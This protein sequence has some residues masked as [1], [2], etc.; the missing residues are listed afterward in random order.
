MVVPRGDGSLMPR[1]IR[2]TLFL[3]SGFAGSFFGSEEL[4]L[5]DLGKFMYGIDAGGVTGFLEAWEMHLHIASSCGG[6]DVLGK[7]VGFCV[8]S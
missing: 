7:E 8:K 5:E 6:F 4:M 2:S 1:W 3:P